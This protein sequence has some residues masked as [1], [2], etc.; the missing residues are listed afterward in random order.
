[1]T[2]PI[3]GAHSPPAQPGDDGLLD[4]LTPE[5]AQ[6]VRHGTGPL[7]LI[8][9]P[10]AGKTKT[11]IHRIAR[12]LRDGVAQPWEILAVTF[13]V[14]AAGELRLRLA[15]LL[16]EQV[17]RGVTAATFHSI[18]ARILRE[19]ASG[20][21]RTENYTVY[22]QTDVRRVIEWLLSDHQRGQIQQAL[23]DHGQPAAA[24]VLAEI[25]LA[26][27][28]LLSPDSYEQAARHTAA[29]LIAAVWREAEIELQ[30]SNAWSFDDLLVFGVRLLA[31]HPHRLAFYR[32]R[33]RWL[34]ADEFQ[35]TNEAQGVLI[36]L[37]AGP[38]GNVCAVA[39]DDQLI[40]SFRGAEPRNVLAF[41]E[42][43]PAHARI[44]LGRNFRCRAEILDAAVACVAHNTDREAKALIAMRG[45]GGEA[46]AIAYG[47]DRDEADSVAA[48]IGQTLAD[49]IPAGEV[50]VLARTGYASGP[51]QAALA[52]HGLP[53]RVLG[54][55]GLYE[56]S[57]VRD[58]LAY[59]TLLVN[60][61]DAQAF[62]RAIGSPKRGVGATTAS[63]VVALAR[64]A[65]NGDLITA[66]AHADNLESVR[67]QAMRERLVRFGEGLARVRKD[68]R[69]GRSL[70]HVAIATLMLSGGL[71]AHHQH[72]RDSSPKPDE[73]QDAERVLEDLRSLCRAAQA[74]AEHQPD[75]ATLAGFLEQAAGLHA[76][77][78]AAGEPDRR[79]TV[80]TIHRAKGTE[81]RLVV[82]LGCEERLLPSW[83]ALQSPDGERLAEERRLFYVACTRAKD[84]LILTYAATRGGRP[85]G[86]PSRFLTEAR[87]IHPPQA[88]AA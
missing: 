76:H 82:L 49:G 33:W 23:A 45:A 19:H 84:Q 4:G 88:L 69:A 68:L 2:H 58:A 47:S 26:K 13:S 59:L 1:M 71:V 53:H 55:L 31:E 5:Q 52:R 75:H 61:A 65:H 41:G 62:R 30:R 17:A 56:R 40:Y 37:L 83:R 11:L 43:F 28:R 20:F 21:G 24:E 42:R 60:P 35:D 85:T 74:Y 72:R 63:R 78:L 3:P 87:L 77:E 86:G 7:L 46:R 73:R 57:E 15:D 14:R 32:R 66:A 39:D 36:A 6:A 48:A 22:D 64:D 80:S 79:I 27:N 54:S 12:L 34:V 9:G 51:V 10:G 67:S 25:S 38:D 50:L 8:A 44:V 16:G 18:C 81:A 70:G 29:P